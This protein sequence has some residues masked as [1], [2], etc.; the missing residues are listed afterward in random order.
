MNCD[1]AFELLTDT[2]GRDSV[3]LQEHLESC[4]RC[5]QMQDVLAPALDLLVPEDEP[6][7]GPAESFW[8]L[9]GTPAAPSAGL[10]AEALLLAERTAAELAREQAAPAPRR[11]RVGAFLRYAAVFLLGAG[12]AFGVAAIDG[13]RP[14]GPTAIDT[15]SDCLWIQSTADS[16]SRLKARAPV[17]VASCVGCHRTG[18][19]TQ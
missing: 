11:F 7:I 17:V 3:E 4:A 13:G 5:R 14:G 2:W 19:T 1:Q 9:E 10:S 16:E 8:N 18:T 12:F 6:R 15:A